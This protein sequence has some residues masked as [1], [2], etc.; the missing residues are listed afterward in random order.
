[1]NAREKL[2]SR[3]WLK[4]ERDMRELKNLSLYQA[5]L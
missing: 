5:D 4:H 3:R 2:R 1:M